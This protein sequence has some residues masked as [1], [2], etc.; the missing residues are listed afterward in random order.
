MTTAPGTPLIN[1]SSL[2]KL[3]EVVLEWGIQDAQWIATTLETAE[4]KNL[5]KITLHSHGFIEVPFPE[6]H[7]RGWRDLDRLLLQLWTLRSVR[8]K[9]T[10]KKGTEGRDLGSLG[11][12]LLPE[13]TGRGAIDLVEFDRTSFSSRLPPA[14]LS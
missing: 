5:R 14:C 6:T 11:S 8:L 1:L 9:I 13:L 4:S 10:F 7:L 2:A 3:E 12:M